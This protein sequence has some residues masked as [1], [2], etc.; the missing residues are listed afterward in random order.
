MR[1]VILNLLTG[2][3]NATH[4]LGRWSW[5]CSSLA[6]TGAGIWNACHGVIFDL[7]Q[8]AT[9]LSAIAGAHGVALFA[10]RDTEP[11]PS[12]SDADK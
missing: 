12:N 4:D 11:N 1:K 5:V 7:V 10:K 6:V 2:K 9:A 3:D 8:V